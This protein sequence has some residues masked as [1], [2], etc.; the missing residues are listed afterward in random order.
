MWDSKLSGIRDTV[1]AISTTLDTAATET[2]IAAPGAGKRIVI[3]RICLTSNLGSGGAAEIQTSTEGTLITSRAL[4]IS[5]PWCGSDSG[6]LYALPEDRG[7]VLK[8]L[9]GTAALR[10]SV[11]YVIVDA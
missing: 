9:G 2:I 10:G 6:G 8:N 1:V 11:H 4:V 3:K 5:G 7:L